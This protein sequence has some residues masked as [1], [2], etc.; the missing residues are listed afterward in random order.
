MM[1][2]HRTQNFVSLGVLLNVEVLG[3]F[4]VQRERPDAWLIGSGCIPEKRGRFTLTQG[5]AAQSTHQRG[6]G[7]AEQDIWPRT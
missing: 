2:M 6:C 1:D 3:E 7:K 4:Y 5:P